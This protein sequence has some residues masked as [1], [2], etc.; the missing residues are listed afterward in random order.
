MD[1][2]HFK[3]VNDTCGHET[4]DKVLEM[5]AGT[6]LHNPKGIRCRESLG[7]GRVFDCGS[8]CGA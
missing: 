4:G 1:L 5:V 8:L 2:D 6:L 7:W 3:R